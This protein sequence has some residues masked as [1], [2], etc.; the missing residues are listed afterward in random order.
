MILQKL[1]KVSLAFQKIKVKRKVKKINV[2]VYLTFYWP[3]SRIWTH[4]YKI[5]D[6]YLLLHLRALRSSHQRHS[7][8][9]GVLR[10]FAKFSGK[11]LRQSLFFNKVAGSAFALRHGCS[12]VNLRYIFRISFPK[13]TSKGLLFTDTLQHLLKNW[14]KPMT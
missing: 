11:H 6:Y 8:K 2:K 1:Y 5:L 10:N 14:A 13:N 12:P 9:T 7:V 3:E 4:A